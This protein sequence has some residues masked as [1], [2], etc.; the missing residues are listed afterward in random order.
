[1][2]KLSPL[3]YHLLISLHETSEEDSKTY[4]K[5]A[6]GCFAFYFTLIA[7]FLAVGLSTRHSDLRTATEGQTGA[8]GTVAKP[9]AQHHP[10]G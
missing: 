9:A 1:M 7:G 4:K 10:G 3:G 2:T 6:R 5:W 8:V